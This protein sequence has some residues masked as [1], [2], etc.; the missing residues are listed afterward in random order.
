MEG[1]AAQEVEQYGERGTPEAELDIEDS[2]ANHDNAKL[3]KRTYSR[4]HHMTLTKLTKEGLDIT[5]AK[6]RARRAAQLKV[7]EMD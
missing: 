4:E 7:A 5:D 6:V 2:K 3:Y 1:Q